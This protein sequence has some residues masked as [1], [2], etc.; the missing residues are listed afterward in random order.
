MTDYS[1]IRQNLTTVLAELSAH[2]ARGGYPTPQLVAV[3]KS[4]GDEEV[5]ALAACGVTAMAENRVQNFNARYALLHM[6]GYNPAM[7]L[8]G[9]LQTN[10]VKYVAEGA[11]LIQSLDSL[12]LAAEIERQAVRV[13][14]RIDV[15]CE[16][17]S[18]REEVKGGLLPEQV[19]PFCRMVAKGHYP[20]LVLR[21]LMT[22]APAMKM[23][24]EYRPYFHKTRELYESAIAEGLFEG[25]PI[26][27]M[28]MSD[29]YRIAAEEGATMVRVG[30]GL[31]QKQR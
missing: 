10:K 23:E 8:I 6:H 9:S 24:D 14:R 11:A 20:H 16:V 15:L 7:H 2:A 27:S 4:A 26:L 31:F 3:T 18:G 13:G 30:R 17:N 25:N 21:G 1:Y 12:R 5:L 22:M 28:G 19:L 29:S